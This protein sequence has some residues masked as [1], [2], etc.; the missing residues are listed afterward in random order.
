MQQGIHQLVGTYAQENDVNLRL[1]NDIA[2]LRKTHR[3][4][5]LRNI[6]KFE[7]M[8]SYHLQQRE[9]E[10]NKDFF[11]RDTRALCTPR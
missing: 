2:P 3:R 10:W 8:L 5:L 4:S 6:Y 7:F 1:T 9:L 11:H